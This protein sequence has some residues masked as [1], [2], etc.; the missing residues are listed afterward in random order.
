MKKSLQILLGLILIL[1]LAYLCFIRVSSNIKN[2]L[3]SKTELIY[4]ENNI[5]GVTVEIEGEDLSMRRVLVLTGTISSYKKKVDAEIFAKNI[6]GVLSV[7]NSIVI[8]IAVDRKPKPTIV[9]IKE[10][11]E[12][13]VTPTPTQ[14]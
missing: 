8:D 1:I 7:K 12:V 10:P 4:K 13:I 9:Y 14:T 6:D 3:I 5:T 2:D 11:V